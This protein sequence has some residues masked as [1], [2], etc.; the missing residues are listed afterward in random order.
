MNSKVLFEVDDERRKQDAKWGEQNHP[1]YAPSK[2][3][4]KLKLVTE[5]W[6]KQAKNLCELQAKNGE[7]NWATILAEEFAEAMDELAFSSS[8]KLRAELIQ[9]AAV[10][11][12]WI[13]CI[14]RRGD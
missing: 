6:V 10:C 12:A 11:V 2:N 7:L 1:D 3:L 5:K 13:E 8:S 9:V 14:D 4:A